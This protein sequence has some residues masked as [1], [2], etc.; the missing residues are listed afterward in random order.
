MKVQ[1]LAERLELVAATKLFDR[2]VTGVYISDMVSDVIANAK[3]GDLLVTAQAHANVIAA[4]NLVD[5][6]AIVITQGKPLG[7]DVV[8]MAEKAEIS[9]FTTALNRWQVATKLYEAGV[10]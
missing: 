1:E 7:E 8:K 5:T 3:A 6:C 4:A 10:R 9:V 2:D